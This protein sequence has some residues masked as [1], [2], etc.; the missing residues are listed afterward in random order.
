MLPAMAEERLGQARTL[1][2]RRG[3]VAADLLAPQIHDS[4][5][6]CLAA[7]LDPERPPPLAVVDEATLREPATGR[8]W[9]CA[10]SGRR[11]G[12]SITRSP[13]RTS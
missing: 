8:T 6:R 9:R 10:W 1:L 3:V 12:T 7:G 5:R 2:E 11:C 13:A 4:W